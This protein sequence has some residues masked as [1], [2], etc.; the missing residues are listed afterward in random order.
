[1]SDSATVPYA[2][3]VQCSYPENSFSGFLTIKMVDK[4]KMK[5]TVNTL[6]LA[7]LLEQN[8]DLKDSDTIEEFLLTIEEFLL[9]ADQV[10]VAV[11]DNRIISLAVVDTN[12]YPSIG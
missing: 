3:E 10:Q 2:S 6:A 12:L 9:L 4:I 1:M 5:L 11:C 7:P 8:T